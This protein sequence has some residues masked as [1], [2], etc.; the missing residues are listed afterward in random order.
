MLTNKTN[1]QVSTDQELREL[2]QQSQQKWPILLDL[3]ELKQRA[4]FYKALGD[5]TR[6]KIL[7]MLS[8][9][10][11][12]LCEMISGLQSPASTINHHLKILERGNLITYRKEGKFTIYSLRS[13]ITSQLISIL[14][15]EGD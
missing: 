6:L 11:L 10:D 8:M 13:E 1:F 12:C 3:D 2:I 15:K 4:E 7:G 5:E 14:K 9:H